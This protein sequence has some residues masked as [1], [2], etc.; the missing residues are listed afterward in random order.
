MIRLLTIEELSD[1]L[2]ISKGSLYNMTSKH[3]IPFVKVGKRI[4]FDEAEID[5]WL[6][7]QKLGP[8]TM[9]D[10]KPSTISS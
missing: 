4:R 9:E 8:S 3:S 10:H 5:R 1:R 2:G 6:E 7:A